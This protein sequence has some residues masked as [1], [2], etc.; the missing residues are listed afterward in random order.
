MEIKRIV[1]SGYCKGVVNAINIVKKARETYRDEPI[2]VLGM[3]VHNSFVSEELDRMGIITLNDQSRSKEELLDTIDRGVVIFTAHGIAD[4]I[5]N[6]AEDKGLICIDATCSDVRKTQELVKSYLSEGYDVIY[7]GKAGHPEAE[8]VLSISKD[9]HFVTG[10]EDIAGLDIRNSKIV[11]T[12]QTTM[13]YLELEEMFGILKEKYPHCLINEEICKATSA[14]QKAVADIR[15]GDVLYVVG[16][17]KSN[18]TGKLA[19]IGKKNFRNVYLIPSKE[20]INK[21]DLEGQH[22]I[23]VTAGASTPPHLIDGVM[24]YLEELAAETGK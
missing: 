15:D 24:K 3:I 9:I 22:R 11:I 7:F 6:K 8:S 19:S 14:R 23:Y 10:K 4:S 2:Y 12:N 17:V 13:S 1:P 16:D 21:K 18:N 20:G 5:K